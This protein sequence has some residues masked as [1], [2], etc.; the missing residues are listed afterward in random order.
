M[1]LNEIN[2]T[3]RKLIT[4]GWNDP[5]LTLLETQHLIPFITSVERYIVEA[6]LNPQQISQLFTDVEAGA[7]A[8]GGNRNALGKGTDAV[9][10]VNTKMKELGQ[11]VKKTG[12]VQNADAKFAELKAKI[13]A[14]DGKVVQA[15]QG[16]SDWA[17]EN[18]GKAT[19]AVS[20][21]T[22]AAGMAGGPLGGAIGG[23]LMRA[24]KDLLQGKDLSSAVGSSLKTAAVGALVGVISNNVDFGA[25]DVEG[26]I[27]TVGL[28]TDGSDVVDAVGDAADGA[29]VEDILANLTQAEYTQEMA[30]KLYN[31]QI[32]RFGGKVSESMI[33]KI[34]DSI[35]VSGSYPDNFS[36]KIDGSFIRGSIFLNPE[37][38]SELAKQ[39]FQGTE[40]LGDEASEWLKNNVEGYGNNATADI[41]ASSDLTQGVEVVIND[42]VP[43]EE[44][45]AGE[46]NAILD[47]PTQDGIPQEVLDQYNSQLDAHVQSL[48]DG[49]DAATAANPEDP[50][51]PGD[52]G[53][54]G[55]DQTSAEVEP[56]TTAGFDSSM[57]TADEKEL[58]E[59]LKAGA[60]EGKHASEIIG[61]YVDT[62]T[63]D[64]PGSYSATATEY[65]F[66]AK[67]T[68]N[69]DPYSNQPEDLAKAF[70]KSGAAESV[71]FKPIQI[72]TIIEWCDQSPAVMLTEG[73]L[74]AIK[75]GAA[76]AGG[77]IKKGAAAVGAKAAKVGKGLTTKV[78]ADK[79]NKA[80][81]AA[82]K[83]TD[84]DKIAGV[85]RQQGVDDK[86]LAPVY[87]QLGA[88]L[89]PAP[90]AADPKAPGA[91][92]G[93]GGKPAAAG[94]A[95]APGAKPGPGGKPAA[96]GQAAATGMD[97]KAVQQAVAKLSPQ[98]ATAL[99]QHIDSLA[100]APQTA[101]A[102]GG[103][104]V[105]GVTAPAEKDPAKSA[106][107]GDTFE[108]AKGDIRKVQGGQKPMPPK[109]AATIA[110]DLTK[111][112]K[113]DKESGVAAAQKIMTFAKAGVDVSKQQQA[114][115]ANAKA[116]ERFLTQS[117][118]FEISKMLRENNLRWSDLGIRIHLLEGTN[119]MF[120]I[121]YI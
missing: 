58:A 6:N 27:N 72:E 95:A 3:K 45:S 50:D 98:D 61:D 22:V 91:K 1:R 77:A 9:K 21:L 73:P 75:K 24:T 20:I 18:P 112:S 49:A 30:E 113:G 31:A 8:S 92:P 15:I 26:G 83:P 41:A 116:G 40:I 57:W 47:S 70:A 60:A 36:A 56:E 100:A 79:L 102:A 78:T 29:P 46:M 39:G 84:S 107:A 4:E 117:V 10:F 114:W 52:D 108:K 59:L 96:A 28:E 74:D 37:E 12:P 80:W 103:N 106:A 110:S 13:G 87:K 89:P 81:T 120:G 97:F 11:A 34:A 42:F 68:L 25:Q 93:P 44:L 51:L 48:P 43:G 76:A 38:A 14:K 85:L 16:V 119:K 104:A 67:N 23:F 69:I 53:D 105:S 115:V 118:Y 99:V 101:P 111:L 55:G 35:E 32:E 109:T 2:L 5:R 90:V 88:K 121:S 7:T 65:E 64:D 17:K 66:F 71:N 82:G 33:A 63:A 19:I 94:Q 62:M 54:F 86:V